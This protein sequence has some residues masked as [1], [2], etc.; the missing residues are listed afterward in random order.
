MNHCPIQ[1]SASREDETFSLSV[2]VPKLPS[3]RQKPDAFTVYKLRAPSVAEKAQWIH[4]LKVQDQHFAS[5][6]TVEAWMFATCVCVCV[7]VCRVCVCAV[8]VRVRE[9]KERKERKRK[10]RGG[11]AILILVLLVHTTALHCTARM[12]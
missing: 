5:V 6:G 3:D 10:N 2:P 12:N 11:N 4:H 9:G 1:D 8:C 7:C